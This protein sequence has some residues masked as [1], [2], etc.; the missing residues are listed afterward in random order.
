MKK[1]W[2]SALLC[3]SAE[4]I[5][6]NMGFRIDKES[7]NQF[8]FDSFLKRIDHLRPNKVKKKL[9]SIP[10]SGNRPSPTVLLLRPISSHLFIAGV[11]ND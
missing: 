7:L 1:V 10:R 3:S 5:P 9:F 11:G 8:R 2:E 4:S 6:N